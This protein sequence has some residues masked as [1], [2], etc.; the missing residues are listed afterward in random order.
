MSTSK[1][2]AC[3]AVVAVKSARTVRFAQQ[4]IVLS[5][6][7][8]V[9]PTVVEIVWSPTPIGRTVEDVE[10]PASQEKFALAALALRRV[11]RPLPPIVVELVST[12]KPM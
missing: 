6:V 5:V 1:P 12:H 8:P 7:L 11:L 10:R 9:K 3:T 2:T 4:V